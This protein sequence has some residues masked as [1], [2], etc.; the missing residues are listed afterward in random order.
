MF[1]FYP[2]DFGSAFHKNV[3]VMRIIS[4][5]SLGNIV[6]MVLLLLGV[7]G[8]ISAQISGSVFRDYN[9]NGIKESTEPFLTGVVVNA[10]NSSN[11]LC[12][13]TT[14]SGITAPNYSLTGCGSG[15]VRIEFVI[16]ASGG[17]SLNNL[18]DFTSGGGASY[19]SSVQFANGNSSNINFAV[20]APEDYFQ[21]SDN[22]KVFT[23]VYYNGNPSNSSVAASNAFMGVN[24]DAS[25]SKSN[26]ATVGQIGSTWG[27][28]FSKQAQKLFTSA[29]LKRHVGLG[30]LGS[31]GIYMIDP[32]TNAVTN[33]L[34]LDALGIAT[35]GSGTYTGPGPLGPLVPFSPVIGTNAERDLG[36]GLDQPSFDAPAYAQIGRLSLGDIDISDDGRYLFVMNLFNKT[37][38]RIDLVDP[39]N[40]QAPTLANASTRISSWAVPSPGCT[41]GQHRPFGLE[42]ARGNLF[43]GLVC[44]GENGGTISDLDAYVYQVTNF[45]AGTYSTLFTIPLDYDKGYAIT[46]FGDIP[47]AEATKG[48]FVWS[49]DAGFTSNYYLDSHPQ[50]ILSDIVFDADGSLILAFMDRLGHQL[51]WNNYN[52][53]NTQ[54]V[55]TTVGGD[56]LRA[57]FNPSG[58]VYE[59]ENNGKEGPSS[60]KPATGGANNGEGPGGGEFYYRDCYT[61]NPDGTHQET[62]QGGIAMALGSGEVAVAVIDPSQY[63]SGGLTWFNNTTG[64]DT[65]DYELYFTGNS[66]SPP[67]SGTF[68]KANGLG[69]ME[70]SGSAAPIEIGNRVWLDTDGDGIQDAGETPIAG[71]TVQLVK[72]GTVI[73]TATTDANGNYYFSSGTGTNTASAIYGISQLMPN[74]EYIV[75][76]PNVQG[77]SKQAALG[78]NSLTTANA[79]GTTNGD[80][81]DS[82]GLLVGNNA[83]VTVMTTDIA[84]AGA[85]NHTFDFGFRPLSCVT[86]TATAASTN[87]TC[88]GST[89]QSNG[90]ITISGFT[91]G[92]R[93]QYTSGATFSGTAT[94]ASITAI[95]VGG[96]IVNNLANTTQQYTVRIYDA[97]DDVCF[98]DRTVSITAATCGSCN[99]KEYIYLNE[100]E[101]GAVLKFEIGAGVPLTEVTGTNGPG[102]WYPG[103]GVSELPSPHGLGTDLNGNLYI[104]SSYDVNT[105]IRKFNCDGQIAP[106]SPT[107]INNQFTL[108]NM[109]S[110][111]N[112]IYTTRSG[113]PAAY[114][115]CTG[116]LIGTMCLNDQNGNPLPNINGIVRSQMNWGLSYNAV[117][118]KVYATG[119]TSPRQSV[120]VFTENQLDAGIA[121]G[122]CISPLIPL[123]TTSVINI[124][125]N[126][127]PN[128]IEDLRGVVSDNAG[129]IYVTGWYAG[130]VGFILK[131]NAAGQFQA[132]TTTSS[133]YQLTIGIIWSETTNRIYVSNVT[134]D[135]NVDCISAF[136]ATTLAY[137]GTAAPNPNL[138]TNNTAK[139]IAIIKECCPS[140]L[141]ATFQKEVCG[142]VGTKFY[143]NQEAFD[144]CD[145]IVCGSSW[146][147]VGTLTNMT[148]DAC[149][150][151][152]IVTGPGCGTF[153]L[154]IGA[155]ISTGCGAQTSTFTICNTVPS[156]TVAAGPAGT[157]TGSTPNN[158]AVINITAATNA[159]QAGISTGATY[160]G[161][162]YNGAGTV[163]ITGG[164]AAFT[165]RMHNTQYTVRIFNGSNDCFV[166]YTITTPTV[167]CCA[168]A[169]TCTPVSQTSCTPVNGSASVSAT[170]AVGT[171]TYIWSSGETTSSI[172]SKGAGTYIVTV[173]DGGVAGCSRTC[174]A[175]ITSTATLPTAV[176]TPVANTNCATPNGSAS[177][178]TNAP[179]ATY[180]WSNNA[181][182]SSIT[183][184]NAGTYIVTVT[185]TT[186]GCT[187]TCQAVVGSTTTLPTA[188]CSKTD[189]TN[190][191]TPNGS[192]TV[193]TNANQISWSTGATT[194]SITG[195][196]AGTYTVTVT[197][198]TTG[199]TN[200]CSVAVVNNLIIPTVVCTP[201][202]PTCAAP[203]DGSIQANP[204]GGSSPYTYLWSNGQ[205]GSTATGLSSGTYTVTVNDS[206]GCSSNCSSDLNAPMGCCSIT[207]QATQPPGCDDNGTLAK[208][209]DDRL[210]FSLNATNTG[211]NTNY[212]ITVNQ[213][214]VS[215]SVGVYGQTILYTMQPG[216]AGQGNV[217]VT[218]TDSQSPSCKSQIIISDPGTCS[219]GSVCVIGNPGLNN[220]KCN[221]NGTP[222]TAIDDYTTFTLNPTGVGNLDGYNVQVLSTGFS[223]TPTSAK[224]GI[225]QLFTLKLGSASAMKIKLKITDNINTDCFFEI[226][227]LSNGT[228]SNCTNPPCAPINVIKN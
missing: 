195:L 116:A 212:L 208:D 146:I 21:A 85:N 133:S 69:D 201:F 169:V 57:Y 19:G 64:T 162:I 74:M 122:A 30:P 216:S 125:D 29:F 132:A 167:T 43:V 149:D 211:L 181:T 41:N 7:Q 66:N 89:A 189:N 136:D 193:T 159:N 12:G 107:T 104:G 50:P 138:P 148:F 144:E 87:P 73:A 139:A 128:N 196:S 16:P 23:P 94:P 13:T 134:D 51:G 147:P 20:N 117:T 93:Y 180:V 2:G 99:C 131:Y 126:F 106:L 119:V 115:S 184:L 197:N 205:S 1:R 228:C 42:F 190:C 174:Q 25:G 172:S 152:V 90:M 110:I 199:C 194:A 178:S 225:D 76:I 188:T 32:N 70:V 109:F 158:D 62:T 209:T 84:I 171:L 40:P 88:S 206:N 219:P 155:V 9:A 223:V 58:C 215:P 204:S 221:D 224:Y 92:Q 143:L 222:S 213:G 154:N 135:P 102:H 17:C 210:K 120:W 26:I 3:I 10:Y 75:R 83:E 38:Y 165:G 130:N 39:A 179:S 100:P 185:N 129:N 35:R 163:A 145:G 45:T 11:A 177:V 220:V 56:L 173:T 49:D 60:P 113:G 91:V 97:T 156:A 101:I 175:V 198:T 34:D 6:F 36:N 8:T 37:I 141:P 78:T 218:I 108:T 112:T 166:D 79:D 157:C 202:Q 123:G 207:I 192:A 77:G 54:L 227:I 103:N 121:G 200:T 217:I 27:V 168:L 164:I 18:I 33:W 80:Y 98:I 24:F 111:G 127:L 137:L 14:T 186:T 203:N 105:P 61:C 151:S 22:P 191:A 28:A 95:P 153:T 63:E 59:L 118:Q 15:S 96:V 55:V 72:N 48:W 4:I 160:T 124:G 5:K 52:P 68:S 140:N 226:E 142:A 71:I 31:G 161:P 214:S 82:D 44:S 46:H 65:K 86:P 183:G 114:N 176:C 170:G 53:H 150:N 47:A 67:P 81:R 187:N 182:T